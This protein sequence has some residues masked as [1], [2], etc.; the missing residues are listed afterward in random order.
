[1][2][3]PRRSFGDGLAGWQLTAGGVFLLPLTLILEGVPADIDGTALAG[4]AWLGI[5]GGLLTYTLWFRGIGLLPVTSVAVL[6]L[7]SPLVAATL[8]ALLLGQTL[9]GVQLVGFALALA[10]IVAGQVI[11]KGRPDANITRGRMNPRRPPAD[12]EHIMRIAIIGAT[13]TVGSRIAAESVRRGH[14]VSGVSRSA[15]ADVAATPGVTLTVA[16]AIDADAMR[17]IA[18]ENDV[19][20]LATRPT[21]GAEHTVPATVTTV[22]GAALAA[23]RRGHR[24]RRRGPPEQPRRSRPPRPR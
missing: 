20:V 16:D 19:I 21:P 24:D 13:G 6:G 23:G 5:V 17:R 3:T 22:L 10:A 18:A 2:G 9:G 15:R 4:Y 1:M 7:I 8:G 14:D 11:P 12:R